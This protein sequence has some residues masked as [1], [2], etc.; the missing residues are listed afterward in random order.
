MD[1]QHATPALAAIRVRPGR[2]L[3]HLTHMRTRLPPRVSWISA[4]IRPGRMPAQMHL[5]GCDVISAY[6]ASVQDGYHSYPGCEPRMN[7]TL[8]VGIRPGRTDFDS[9][10]A[11]SAQR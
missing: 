5:R 4:S 8:A 1:T 9:P 2:T 10:F 7:S 3:A 11:K 6:W